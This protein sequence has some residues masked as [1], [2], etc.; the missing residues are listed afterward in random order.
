MMLFLVTI[1][2]CLPACVVTAEP[3]LVETKF[4]HI[5]DQRHSKLFPVGF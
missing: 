1:W 5:H 4:T 2:C 3:V